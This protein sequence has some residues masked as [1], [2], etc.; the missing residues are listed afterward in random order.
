M[1]CEEHIDHFTQKN[2]ISCIFVNCKCTSQPIID[3]DNQHEKLLMKN[4]LHNVTSVRERTEETRNYI[5][6]LKRYI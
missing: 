2:V 6:K 1:F 3:I 5:K 4:V